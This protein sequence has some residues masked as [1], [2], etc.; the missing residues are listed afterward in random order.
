MLYL[1]NHYHFYFTWSKLT[2][3]KS[4]V[5]TLG[6]VE[7]IVEIIEAKIAIVSKENFIFIATK[8]FES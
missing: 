8:L 2:F 3:S 1:V 7:A 4:S 5:G 6:H